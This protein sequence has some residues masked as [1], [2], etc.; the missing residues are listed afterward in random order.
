MYLIYIL[1]TAVIFEIVEEEGRNSDLRAPTMCLTCV[2]G[3]FTVS[4]S[5]LTPLP[6]GHLVN[7]HWRVK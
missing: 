7:L 1:Y 6:S 4:Q 5:I 3:A 2:P